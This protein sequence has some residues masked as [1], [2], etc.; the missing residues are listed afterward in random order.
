MQML[1]P[2][3]P[4]LINCVIGDTENGITAIRQNIFCKQQLFRRSERNRLCPKAT[5]IS[6]NTLRMRIANVARDWT[7][8]VFNP[9]SPSGSTLYLFQRGCLCQASNRSV[10]KAVGKGRELS[11]KNFACAQRRPA[12]PLP[13]YSNVAHAALNDFDLVAI[14]I[15]DKEEAR[16]LHVTILKVYQLAD[17]EAQSCETVMFC[18]KGIDHKS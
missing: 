8:R 1:I 7:A 17:L 9:K 4:V 16:D 3:M 2:I 15:F 11:A 12:P 14:R 5:S 13:S 18:I 6:A 10:L